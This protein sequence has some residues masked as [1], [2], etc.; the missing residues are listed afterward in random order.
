MRRCRSRGISLVDTLVAS[1]VFAGLL[2]IVV[3]V[4]QMSGKAMRKTDV[5]TETWRAATIGLDHVRREVRGAK[6]L[7]VDDGGRALHFIRPLTSG[8]LLEITD[9]GSI[10]F[11]DLE[12]G[13]GHS[14]T[15]NPAGDLVS[16][17]DSTREVHRLARL[18]LSG[19]ASFTLPAASVQLLHVTLRAVTTDLYGRAVEESTSQIE[20]DLYLPN[21]S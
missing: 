20:A 7:V 16:V 12:A 5:H 18:G 17:D 19:E 3:A 15:T 9:S 13:Q 10:K 14:L 11:E 1:A 8:G 4:Q 21:D 2:V 6:A